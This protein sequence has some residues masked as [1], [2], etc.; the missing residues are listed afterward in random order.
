MN[1]TPPRSWALVLDDSTADDSIAKGSIAKIAG[2]LT[3]IDDTLTTEGAITPDALEALAQ[4]KPAGLPVFAITGRPMG[5]SM[6]FIAPLDQGGWPLDAIVSENGAVALFRGPDGS[7][8]IEYA[9]DDA[10]RAH[11]AARLREVAARVIREVPGSKLSQDSAGRVTD[12]AVD[13][14]EFA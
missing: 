3:D 9:Q 11:N 10:T 14:S 13:H 2:V 6:P 7:L 12:I 8:A 5:W 4:L 1:V